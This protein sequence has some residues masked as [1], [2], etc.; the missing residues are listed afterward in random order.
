VWVLGGAWLLSLVLLLLLL[1][2]AAGS[3]WQ[4]ACGCYLGSV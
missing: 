3:V 2:C 1:A 4:A